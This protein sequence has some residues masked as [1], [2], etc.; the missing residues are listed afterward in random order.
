MCSKVKIISQYTMPMCASNYHFLLNFWHVLGYLGPSRMD[1]T[2]IRKVS[3]KSRLS[4]SQSSTRRRTILFHFPVFHKKKDDT[5]SKNT[6]KAIQ[7]NLPTK[8]G[9]G[10]NID[11]R[12][13]KG[14][15]TGKLC[16]KSGTSILLAYPDTMHE[17]TCSM[18]GY[19]FE[20][21]TDL[22]ADRLNIAYGLRRT[23]ALNDWE[24]IKKIKKLARLLCL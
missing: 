17:D 16:C 12:A 11:I 9:K 19:L 14:E 20:S 23:W 22:Y 15:C 4:F 3:R 7:D 6:A 21:N 2:V 13:V 5:V 10:N 18:T 24:N 1:F 8:D